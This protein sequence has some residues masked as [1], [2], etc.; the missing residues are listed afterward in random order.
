MESDGGFPVI[1]FDP[2]TVAELLSGF[3]PSG[4][5]GDSLL[6]VLSGLERTVAAAHAAQARALAEFTRIRPHTPGRRFGEFVADEVAVELCLTRRAAE[7]RVAQAVEMTTR[8]PAVLHALAAGTVDLYRARIITDATY[9]LDD[10]TAARVA[11]HVVERV[12]GRNAS[13]VRD[14]VRRTVLRLDPGGA[15]RRQER[16]RADRSVVLTPV[17]DG[18]AELTALLP[19]EQATA[20][21]RRVDALA[22]TNRVPGDDRGADARRADVLVN[23]LLGRRDPGVA[24]EPGLRPLVHVT[25]A[26]STLAGA[27]D[28]PGM[29]DRY[30]PIPAAFARKIAADPTGVWKRL[31]TDPIDGSLVEHSRNTYRPP[32][33]LDDFVRARDHTCRFPGCQHSAQSADL[34]HTIAWPKGPTTQGNLG[35]LCRHHHR[36]KHQSTWRLT[37]TNGRFRWT[38]PTGRHYTTKPKNHSSP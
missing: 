1:G 35:T 32:A 18:M 12:A 21:Y 31:V 16:A 15:Q 7:N 26:A 10:T 13:Q 37:Q 36:L 34:D 22:R 5:D 27:D 38:S 4:L 17:E 2:V 29:L 30:G 20:V 14:L 33:A 23:L 3:D 6:A 9:R 28:T 24:G 19:A 8:V 25:V 11:G